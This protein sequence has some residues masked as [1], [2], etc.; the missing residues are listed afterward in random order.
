MGID[1]R[2]G[3]DA[4]EGCQEERSQANSEKRRRDVHR[5]EGE[6]RHEPHEQKVLEGIVAEIRRDALRKRASSLS[7]R[8]A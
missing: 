5:E 8:A 4:D 6:E 3:D 7:Q 1:E 2:A